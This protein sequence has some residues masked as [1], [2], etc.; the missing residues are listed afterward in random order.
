ML[1]L[2]L[3]SLGLRG[4]ALWLGRDAKT[5]NDQITYLQRADDLLEGKGYT[6]SYQSWVLHKGQRKMRELP[7]YLGAYQ[8]PGYA[9]FIALVKKL[10]GAD[11][12]W[13]KLA[14]V[15][16]GAATTWLVYALG[17]D[18]V[19]HLAGLCAGWLYAL[20]PTLI[21]FTHYIFTETL[22]LFLFTA[23]LWLWMRPIA[24]SVLRAALAGVSFAL[25]AY[26]KSSV[27]YLLPVLGLW[28]VWRERE[29]RAQALR[30]CAAAALAWAACVAPWTLRNYE[31]HGGFVLMDSSGPFN[32]WRG[33]QPNAYQRRLNN[34]DW[35]ARLAAPFDAYSYAPVAEVGGSV[36]VDLAREMFETDTPTDLQVMKAAQT[37]A[38]RYALDDLGWT[39]RRAFYK[40]VDLWNPTSFVMR[41][42]EREGYGAI[43]PL[44]AAALSWA[45][46]L[47]Y[48]LVWCLALPSLWRRAN[49]A[50]GVMA[51]ALVYYYSLIHMATFG[52]T[53][54]RLPVM[55]IL[56]VLAG[57]TLAAWW[58]RRRHP[59]SVLP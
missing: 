24:P 28:L 20:D 46:V 47:S 38:V 1:V 15:L 37:S 41:H 22:F 58:E 31:V 36:A 11:E 17:R 57:A 18:A 42:L 34:S 54:F 51:L 26:V 13:V 39:V 40:Y 43:S 50:L 27:I 30:F 55:P 14:Q 8:A 10:C 3:A 23:G 29:R 32:L 25:A 19:S 59:A 6:G 49:T 2:V 56:M 9:A 16:L 5:W 44:A 4:G 48:V 7:R 53:R 33:N 52:L 35:N 45:C 21:A 12:L